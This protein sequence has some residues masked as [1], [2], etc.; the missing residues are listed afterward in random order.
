MPVFVLSLEGAP[1]DLTLFADTRD[2]VAAA[3]DAVL[4]L[5]PRYRQQQQQQ[6]Q[7]G[8]GGSGPELRFTGHAANGRRVLRDARDVTR[9]V[10]AGLATAL[11]GAHAGGEG[12]GW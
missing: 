7:G 10:V 9:H 1:D 6:Q 12:G 2:V 4:V 5:Q 3:H 8:G 11:A